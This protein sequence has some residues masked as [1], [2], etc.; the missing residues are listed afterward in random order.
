MCRII[1]FALFVTF[2][3]AG[4]ITKIIYKDCGKLYNPH[5]L[6]CI[7]N[8]SLQF[9]KGKQEVTRVASD[10]FNGTTVVAHKGKDLNFEVDFT[11]SNLRLFY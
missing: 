5:I 3:A 2:A 11:A 8:I 9:F 10:G 4:S 1:Y 7:Y 6:T